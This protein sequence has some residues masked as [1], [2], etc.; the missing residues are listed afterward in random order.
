MIVTLLSA[1]LLLQQPDTLQAAGITALRAVA[2]P[3]E[4]LSGERLRAQDNL[5]DAIRDF[6]GI[7]I[8]DYGGA[9]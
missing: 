1:F 9:G 8:R 6:A 5:A 3:T 4:S 7:Q 2:P